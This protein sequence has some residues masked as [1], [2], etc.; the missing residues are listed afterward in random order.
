M[1][2]QITD[3]LSG[4]DE[5][6]KKD[7]RTLFNALLDA[8]LPPQE[9]S[10]KR[11]EHEAISVIGAGL[12]TTKWALTVASF[13]IL[14]NPAVLARLKEE[15]HMA[16]PDPASIPR[17]QELQR[18]PYLSAV[19]E[20]SKFS[21]LS[22]HPLLVSSNCNRPID[23]LGT[24]ALRLAY[25]T[26]QRGPRLS[27]DTPTNY[28]GWIIPPNTEISMDI[29]SI[30]HDERIFPDSFRFEPARW[31]DSP[32]GPDGEKKL[33]RYM[34]SFG[35]G[36][37]M[38]LGMHLAYAEIYMAIATLFRRFDFELFETEKEDVMCLYDMF[39]PHPRKGSKG[40]RVFVK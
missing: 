12:E 28:A 32:K 25:G 8:N 3:V 33:S 19:I 31:L 20:E 13:Y 38:C 7:Q 24:T 14:D 36:N 21:H 1:R 26:S 27:P 5:E 6:K 11:L 18:L 29:Y 34:V 35:K 37:R 9:T 23:Y 4:R 40:V 15:L 16:I 39:V 10:P 22:P 30:S 2:S 17:L